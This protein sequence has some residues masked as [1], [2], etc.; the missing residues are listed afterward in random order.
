MKQ[1]Q[2]NMS[3]FENQ[4]C[5]AHN[6][7][8][9]FFFSIVQTKEIEI[10]IN[11]NEIIK[12]SNFSM[13]FVFDFLKKKKLFPKCWRKNISTTPKNIKFIVTEFQVGTIEIRCQSI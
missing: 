2:Q 3:M 1:Q 12:L 7:I 13:V 6:L 9:F 8:Y 4:L 10:K 5:Y 11:G